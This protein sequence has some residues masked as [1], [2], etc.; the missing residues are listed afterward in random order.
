V[1]GSIDEIELT[2]EVETIP[3]ASA[4]DGGNDTTMIIVSWIICTYLLEKITQTPYFIVETP[5]EQ[6][7]DRWLKMASLLTYRAVY[8]SD[9]TLATIYR[10]T[11]WDRTTIV[12][13]HIQ[14]VAMGRKDLISDH[15][16]CLISVSILEL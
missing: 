1:V 4:S 16:G 12:I 9:P 3:E 10:L 15:W 8:K 14:D 5:T 7:K 6:V 2:E 11:S 13:D